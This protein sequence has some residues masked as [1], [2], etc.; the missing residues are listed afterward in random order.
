MRSLAAY[1]RIASCTGALVSL[2]VTDVIAQTS[3]SVAPAA[4]AAVG[5]PAP[6]TPIAMTGTWSGEFFVP[7][8][9]GPMSM[10]LTRA[11]S[12]W[13]GTVT[14][15]TPNETMT[16][17]MRKIVVDTAGLIFEATLQG[18]D[19]TFTG[20]LAEMELVGTLTAVQNGNTV[21]QGQWSA[22]RKP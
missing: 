3:A 2:V 18:A 8:G 19:V 16:G 13:A 9:Q 12:G 15:T 14:V 20:K 1:F 5:A 17:A 11:D 10:T 22:R 6:G 7:Q 4:G 21:A